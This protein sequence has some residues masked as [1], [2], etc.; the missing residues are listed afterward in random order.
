M[1][2]LPTPKVDGPAVLSL[3]RNERGRDLVIGDIH[4]QRESF[5]SLLRK[6]AYS[7][8]DGDRLLLLGDLIDRGPD[9]AGMLEWAMRSDVYCIR[10]N[11]EQLLFDALDG[12]GNRDM[13]ELW[14]EGNGGSWANALSA[15]ERDE[16]LAVVREMP[17]AIEVDA[18][19]GTCV[20]VHAEIPE[21]T[22]WWAFKAWLLEG[23]RDCGLFCLWPRIRVNQVNEFDTGV[24]DVWRT[25]HGHTPL[26][27]PITVGNMRWIDLGS[28]YPSEYEGASLACVP[29]GPDGSEGELVAVRILDVDPSQ[30]PD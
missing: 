16:W 14:K 26:K 11:H 29:I 1:A 5:E 9:S 18:P 21:E 30:G 24:E 25:F 19:K 27:V 17:M 8:E 15:R 20:L 23:D 10:G 3:P 2:H 12:D 6:V 7:R 22:P 28:A 4:G 13:D